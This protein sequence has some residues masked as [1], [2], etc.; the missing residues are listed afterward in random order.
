M[1]GSTL[2][3][4][5]SGRGRRQ[6]GAACTQR[7]GGTGADPWPRSP[8]PRRAGPLPTGT[9]QVALVARGLVVAITAL[10]AEGAAVARAAD[11]QASATACAVAIASPVAAAGLL[12]PASAGC[13]G[14][15]QPASSWGGGWHAG[16][17]LQ[18]RQCRWQPRW[19][20][21]HATATHAGSRGRRRRA[22]SRPP[23]CPRTAIGRSRGAAAAWG[24]GD[25]ALS[26]LPSP[27]PP[28]SP[29]PDSLVEPPPLHVLLAPLQQLVAG[30]VRR[31]ADALQY[32][33][34]T[35]LA[36][37]TGGSAWGCV[38]PAQLGPPRSPPR[39]GGTH[40]CWYLAS[41]SS[42]QAVL[43][44]PKPSCSVRSRPWAGGV[45]QCRCGTPR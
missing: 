20:P 30:E 39:L 22:G 45:G 42:S 5:E 2:R 28:A 19:H 1:P 32:L 15:D 14:R 36:A 17:P 35:G 18:P 8:P 34:Q 12:G 6:G 4:G 16:G 43:P 3:A 37:G 26:S 21:A 7:P 25:T 10:G 31:G 38:P 27:C 33:Q 40:L 44:P 29:S 13:M 9:Y 24:G 11:A 41:F 23:A